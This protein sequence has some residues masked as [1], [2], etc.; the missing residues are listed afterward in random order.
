LARALATLRVAS[1][2]Q[3]RAFVSAERCPAL[4]VARASTQNDERRRPFEPPP[5]VNSS[6]PQHRHREDALSHQAWSW[7]R[8]RWP[9]VEEKP[10]GRGAPQ[11]SRKVSGVGH[12]RTV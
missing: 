6:L 8:H 9:S 2:R 7:S 3:A 10:P 1:R 12:C 4:I 11:T 5:S